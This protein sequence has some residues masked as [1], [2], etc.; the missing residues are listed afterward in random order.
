MNGRWLRPESV[1]ERKIIT[2]LVLL[3]FACSIICL[4]AEGV[5]PHESGALPVLVFQT[6]G[7]P[8]QD[9]TRVP[10]S[11]TVLLPEDGGSRFSV[12]ETGSG[13]AE[14]SVRGN[15]SYNY[16]K[17]SYR[18]ELQDERGKDRK[19]PFL[20]LPADSDWVVYGSVT[21]KT[22]TRSV[23]AH[24]LWRS[25]GRYAVRW[26]FAEVFVL[27]NT[28][29]GERYAAPLLAAKIPGLLEILSRTNWA[30]S[31]SRTTGTEQHRLISPEHEERSSGS[32]V[33][34]A[35]ETGRMPVLLHGSGR[36]LL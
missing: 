20:G 19:A 1:G 22:F 10:A 32:P 29:R 16:L 3:L 13:P 34:A 25:T 27:T 26:R 15:S 2:G 24:E 17:K 12:D 28:S 6:E 5:E 33:P 14:L 4:S 30:S 35:F 11:L 36:E 18:L 9:R 21:D 7:K 23:L 31:P 8:V